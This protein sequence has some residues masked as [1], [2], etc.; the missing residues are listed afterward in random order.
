MLTSYTLSLNVDKL[1]GNIFLNSAISALVYS[2]SPPN[3]VY[4]LLTLDKIGRRYS[5]VI[6]QSVVG[7]CCLCLAFVPEEYETA[8]FRVLH[9]GEV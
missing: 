8:F 4:T 5:I 7:V 2:T 9:R 1:A 3:D 6:I